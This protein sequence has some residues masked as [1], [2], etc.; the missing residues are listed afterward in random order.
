MCLSSAQPIWPTE[1]VMSDLL[2][3]QSGKYLYK[4]A[5]LE[6]YNRGQFC[7]P[8]PNFRA[9]RP[10]FEKLFTGTKVWRKARKFGV[11][12]K[13]VYEIDPRWRAP[14]PTFCIFRPA[15]GFCAPR[16]AF[17]SQNIFHRFT[18]FAIVFL[19]FVSF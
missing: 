8:T 15:N 9:L 6:I 10:T 16:T 14:T 7:T 5:Q 18:L 4:K 19:V 3:P 1:G 13:T 12:R 11:G 17:A 2:I